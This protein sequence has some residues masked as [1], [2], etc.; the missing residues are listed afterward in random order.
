MWKNRTRQI[1]LAAMV[2]I[3]FIGLALD[4]GNARA[5]RGS[6]RPAEERAWAEKAMKDALKVMRDADKLNDEQVEELFSIVFP[7]DIDPEKSTGQ[8]LMSFGM[9]F[10]GLIDSGQV[11]RFDKDMQKVY[12]V[13][14]AEIER[15]GGKKERGQ[16]E[17]RAR[18]GRLREGVARGNDRATLRRRRAVPGTLKWSVPLGG[19]VGYCSPAIAEE[20]TIFIGGGANTLHALNPDGTKKWNFAASG[21]V[22]SAP[23]IG[24]DVTIYIGTHGRRIHA[25]TADGAEKWSYPVGD[26][27][28][29]SSPAIG[30]DGTIYVAS[31]DG[32]LYAINGESGG[33]AKTPWPMF[34]LDPHHTGRARPGGYSPP[35]MRLITK[36]Q[37]EM[38]NHNPSRDKLNTFALPVHTVSIDALW[39][40]VYELTNQKYC[41]YLNLAYGLGLIK[42]SDGVVHKA[43]DTESYCDTNKSSPNSR[44]HWDGKVFTVTEGKEE[45]PMVEV[46][47][48]GAVAFANWKSTKAGLTPCYDLETWECNFDAEGFR[49]PTEAESGRRQRAVASTTR[50]LTGPGAIA[51]TV[52]K[53]TTICQATPSTM[54][55]PQRHRWDTMTADKLRVDKTWRTD[56]D[57]TTWRGTYGSGATTGG[58][59]IT[60]AR[61]HTII[62]AALRR[63]LYT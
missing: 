33:L 41:E 6:D 17:D 28:D 47:W 43:G 19:I 39:M 52:Q 36:G 60:P 2:A 5:A 26:K 32:N 61:A 50:I 24:K 22:V 12:D 13:G 30:D 46:S 45:H 8:R 34:G 56:M 9:Y 35:A 1:S 25:I 38:G 62:R 21:A 40:D 20:G 37:Y 10:A 57:Y 15:Q 4:P 49:L 7:K 48:Y 27:I 11:E 55:C 31:R 58:I 3:V 51:S 23:A 63:G 59:L 18:E 44:I 42:V 16:A 53:R 54:T 14:V 29:F